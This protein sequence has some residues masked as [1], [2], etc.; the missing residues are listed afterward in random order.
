M[1]R[2]CVTGGTGNGGLGCADFGD[3]IDGECPGRGQMCNPAG[4]VPPPTTA[5][6]TTS[7]PGGS[8]NA[9][10]NTGNE[11]G[12]ESGNSDVTVVGIVGA[13]IVLAVIGGAVVYV[14]HALAGA[15]TESRAGKSMENPLYDSTP[16]DSA[17]GAVR[18]DSKG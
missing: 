3:A 2:Q 14:K 9:D 15:G 8:S 13:L 6:T 5:A 7:V 12:D 17:T 4:Y 11:A 10:G 18:I 1:C 16:P